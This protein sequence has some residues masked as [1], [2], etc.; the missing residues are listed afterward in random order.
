MSR[1]DRLV[2]VGLALGTVLLS[3]GLAIVAGTTDIPR[4]DDWGFA[5]EAFALHRTGH[6]QFIFWG[7]MT[8]VGHL[9]WA[10]PF[11]AVFGAHRW[12]LSL[13]TAVL[14][15][16]GVAAAF[17]LARRR[18]STFG[19]VT[20]VGVLLV[21]PGVVRDATTYMSDPPALS[22][23]LITLAVGA[24]ALSA[25]GRRR[26]VLFAVSM[27]TG[28]WAFSIR[29][30]ALAAPVAVLITMFLVDPRR[31]SRLRVAAG[32]AVLALAC[33]TLWIWHR[34]LAGVERYRGRP[35]IAESLVLIVSATLTVGLA[36]APALAFS[37]RRW[38][39][40]R[41]RRARAVGAALGVGIV[42]A[43][44]LLAAHLGQ[45]NWWLVGDYLQADG[46]NGGKLLLGWRPIVLDDVLWHVLV[47]IACVGTVVCAALLA[48]WI[49][50]RRSATADP[51]LSLVGWHAGVSA[52][53]LTVAAVVNGAMYDRYLWPL[54]FSGSLLL[55]G[56]RD[57]PSES[58]HTIA[59]AQV[60][61]A[62]VT[63]AAVGA[64]VLLTL[65]SA[66]FDAARWKAATA[67]VR[68]GAIATEVDGGMEWDG[69]HS[70]VP[71]RGGA[72]TGDDPL[73]A[74]WTTL[75]G[76]ERVCVVVTASPVESTTGR[77]VR[78]V[79]WHTF[80]VGGDAVL[81]VYD[82]CG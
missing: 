5:R 57:A 65:N 73:V 8:I 25:S 55:L 53:T 26:W 71:N 18:L 51:V 9:L 45:H 4:T 37:L 36:L 30:L 47:G 21:F 72:S 81:Y 33:S 52:A 67:A 61:G 1:T 11:L 63:V 40:P 16:A 78:T 17:S 82:R 74:W 76:M 29:E 70:T 69:A 13:S 42:A 12:V 50:Q 7:P 75:T 2:A 38:W 79:H 32:G 68:A 23:Q 60:V 44:P 3:W 43:R 48:E 80:L 19:A 31:V 20:S 22:L 77:L 59:A 39:T 34:G 10:Q 49:V 27:L 41:H 28:F 64:C 15:A 56:R 58:S 46:I 6:L 35:P 54:V 62:F 24:G 14:V 66:A